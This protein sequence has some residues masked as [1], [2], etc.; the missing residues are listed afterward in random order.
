MQPV[1]L[2]AQ[3]KSYSK[4]SMGTRIAEDAVKNPTL[5]NNY[6][7]FLAG[8]IVEG[9]EA[10]VF[11]AAFFFFFSFFC[12]LLSPMIT[13]PKVYVNNIIFCGVF[14]TPYIFLVSFLMT[15]EGRARRG[16]GKKKETWGQAET[17]C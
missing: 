2:L 11:F 15:K 7:D 17:G 12:G 8:I 6:L 5:Q 14:V 3:P 10:F 1:T 13:P 9:L 4:S 16:D